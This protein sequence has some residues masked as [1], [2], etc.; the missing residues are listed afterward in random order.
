M[1]REGKCFERFSLFGKS[2]IATD[3]LFE[4]FFLL[5][6]AQLDWQLQNKPTKVVLSRVISAG[7]LNTLLYTTRLFSEELTSEAMKVGPIPM[8]SHLLRE[9]KKILFLFSFF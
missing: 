9:Q 4:H 6:G 2:C 5:N 3:F 7:F 1:V 8:C